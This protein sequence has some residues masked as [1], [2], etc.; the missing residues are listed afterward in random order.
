[1]LLTSPATDV[2]CL[3]TEEPR[4][5]LVL[6]NGRNLSLTRLPDQENKLHCTRRVC[7]QQLL[8]YGGNHQMTLEPSTDKLLGKERDERGDRRLKNSKA[9]LKKKRSKTKL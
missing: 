6:P 4:S 3:P 8:D 7:E 5:P 2:M 1:M 9:Y